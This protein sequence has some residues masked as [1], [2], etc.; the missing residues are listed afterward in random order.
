VERL[1]AEGTPVAHYHPRVLHPLPE[2]T[3]K[4]FIA[5][6]KKVLVLEENYTGQFA[7]HLRAHVAFNGTEVVRVNQ[8]SGLPFTPDEVKAAIAQHA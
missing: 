6:L 7:Q 2:A 3:V 1:R 8:C 4:R 5:P